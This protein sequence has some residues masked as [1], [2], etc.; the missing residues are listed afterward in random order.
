MHA[1]VLT[2]TKRA[3][4]A[5]KVEKQSV[6]LIDWNQ[7]PAKARRM[8]MRARAWIWEATA[9]GLEIYMSA[10]KGMLYCAHNATA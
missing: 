1:Q 6:G 4:K 8:G 10:V 3:K 5:N 7:F 2:H 9:L